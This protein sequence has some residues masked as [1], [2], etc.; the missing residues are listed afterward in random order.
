M[1]SARAARRNSPQKT[2]LNAIDERNSILNTCLSSLCG[3]DPRPL[4]EAGASR[5]LQA[6]GQKV[7]TCIPEGQGGSMLALDYIEDTCEVIS[8]GGGGEQGAGRG[9]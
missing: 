6:L 8:P 9:P 2:S 3:D 5:G 1:T 7:K 4:E